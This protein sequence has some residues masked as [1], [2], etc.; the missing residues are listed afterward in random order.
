MAARHV[1]V[2]LS[3]RNTFEVDGITYV[4]TETGER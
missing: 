3:T 2:L 1:Y 4:V